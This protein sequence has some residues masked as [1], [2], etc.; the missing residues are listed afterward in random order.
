VGWDLKTRQT[1]RYVTTPHLRAVAQKDLAK[2]LIIPMSPEFTR[3]KTPALSRNILAP[4]GELETLAL[5]K[6]LATVKP[7]VIRDWNAGPWRM[8][9]HEAMGLRGEPMFE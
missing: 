9:W 3:T 8:Y 4:I 5:A 1:K 2:R 6:K 7:A